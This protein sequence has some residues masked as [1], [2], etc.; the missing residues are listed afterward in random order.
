[1]P[2]N[3]MVFEIYVSKTDPLSIKELNRELDLDSNYSMQRIGEVSVRERLLTNVICSDCNS[4]CTDNEIPSGYR[5]PQRIICNS[6]GY[7]YYTQDDLKQTD[8]Y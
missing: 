2:I 1:M 3:N 4:V 7:E 5:K 6:C 8:N